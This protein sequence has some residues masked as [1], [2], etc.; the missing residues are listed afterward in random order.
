MKHTR[1]SNR[2]LIIISV[3]LAACTLT[4]C[5]ETRNLLSYRGY[6]QTMQLIA[7]DLAS[8]GYQQSGME[9]TTSNEIVVDETITHY[10]RYGYKTGF[11]QKMA[12]NFYYHN[13]YSFADST[14]N[15]VQYSMAYKTMAYE[16]NVYVTEC[17][18]EGCSTSNPKDFARVCG[19][20]G[21][22]NRIYNNMRTD[23]QVEML[24][25]GNTTL[26]ASGILVL[27]AIVVGLVGLIAD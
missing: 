7:D 9:Q 20:N 15:Q 16:G 2:M 21:T 6:E 25:S 5:K 1:L 17:V 14:G 11:S 18:Q 22:V 3:A 19:P 8:Q 24:D 23:S 27:L 12:N 10:N 26:L 13:R 4:G